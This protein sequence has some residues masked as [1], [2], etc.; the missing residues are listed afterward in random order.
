MQQF[1]EVHPSQLRWAMHNLSS[2]GVPIQGYS[3]LPNGMC[4]IVVTL[5][6]GETAPDWRAAHRSKPRIE[7]GPVLRWVSILA[8]IIAVAAVLY[9]AFAGGDTVTAEVGGMKLD[10]TTGHMVEDGGLW[11]WL[12]DLHFPWQAQQQP[13]Q[14][15]Q[16]QGFRW[17][18]DAAME[19]AAATAESVQ[20]T[21]TVVSGAVL[22]LLVLLIVLALVRRRK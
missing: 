4:V 11:G 5:P 2:Q 17:P 15:A 3:T 20:G 10:P 21:V 22:G 16:Q 1:Y 19:S 18:W 9:F 13:S 6:D 12:P 8:G 14:Q 7:L